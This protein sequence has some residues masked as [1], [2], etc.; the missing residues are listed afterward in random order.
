MWRLVICD[1]H[2]LVARA[3]EAALEDF[4]EFRVVGS[5]VSGHALIDLLRHVDCDLIVLD[6]AMP[7]EFDGVALIA[8]LRRVF[9]AIPILVLSGQASPALVQR[10]LRA[11]AAG[12]ARKSQNIPLLIQAMS[13]VVR[14]MSHVDN[15]LS[16]DAIV[17]LDE[18]LARLSVREMAV[19]RLLLSGST[20]SG[21]ADKLHK[22]IKTISTQKQSAFRKMGI[23][24]DVQLYQLAHL[25][26]EPVRSGSGAEP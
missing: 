16:A 4:P 18:A 1:D 26:A 10:C 19:I 15:G 17:P 2:P 12:F 23:K 5:A 11:G 6:Y 22:S 24:N 25:P 8:Y 13:R 20:V 21:I 3:L 9:P 7:G 14:G